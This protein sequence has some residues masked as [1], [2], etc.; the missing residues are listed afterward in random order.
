MCSWASVRKRPH[1]K[2]FSRTWCWKH[3]GVVLTGT[4][5]TSRGRSTTLQ[6]NAFP[7]DVTGRAVTLNLHQTLFEVK[8]GASSAALCEFPPKVA[9]LWTSLEQFEEVNYTVTLWDTFCVALKKCCKNVD[10][11]I[12]KKL[13]KYKCEPW[14]R[15]M[16]ETGNTETFS[17]YKAFC[18]SVSGTLW[19]TVSLLT[20]SLTLHF[21]M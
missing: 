11:Q 15:Q 18:L 6:R 19:N 20:D 10:F 16:V 7:L 13:N 3:C 14:L 1:E 8:R 4:G 2:T 5:W 12:L 9:N 21:P 17:R